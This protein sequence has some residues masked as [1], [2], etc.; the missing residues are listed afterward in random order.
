MKDLSA[1]LEDLKKKTLTNGTKQPKDSG[2]SRRECERS[3][4]RA[5]IY[6]RYHAVT[7][8]AI[9]R[10]GLPED[11]IIKRNYSEAKEY[12]E[13]LE[14]NVKQGR[15]LI[16]TGGYGTMKTTI[17][18]AILRKWL[19]A[20]HYGLIVPM[21]SLIDNLYTMRTLNRE[22][23]AKY[24]ERIRKTPLLVL[25]DLGSESTDKTWVLDKV[26]SIITERYNRMMPVIV[27]TN[28]S[29]S[30]MAGT[31]SGRIID[32]LRNTADLMVFEA[33]SQRR[34]LWE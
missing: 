26:D 25:D 14:E 21:C 8:D 13:H 6:R 17:A 28:L 20:G 23:W 1:M 34:H 10:R 15:G 33:A 29:T 4:E 11:A 7:F 2:S 16:L 5:G 27:T 12:A 22:E 18:V 30:D 24:E 31:Y 9:E 19:D 3:M 32:R